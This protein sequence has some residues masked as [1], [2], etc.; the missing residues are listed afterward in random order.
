MKK[1]IV[2]P[3]RIFVI[4]SHDSGEPVLICSATHVDLVDSTESILPVAIYTLEKV[5]RLVN[6]TRIDEQ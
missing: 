6:E 5:G 4:E 2:F 3:K 1:R